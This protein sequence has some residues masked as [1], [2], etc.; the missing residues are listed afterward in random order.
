MTRA[1]GSTGTRR[2]GALAALGLAAVTSLLAPDASGQPSGAGNSP[3]GP[4]AAAANAQQI[5]R[6]RYLAAAGDC[7][8][9]HTL[10]RTAPFSGGRPVE[11]P[12]GVVLSANLTPDPETGI[13]RYDNETFYRALHEGI[14]RNGHHLYPAFP[15]PYY[16]RV[17]REDSDAL[18]AYLRSLPPVIHAIDR[19]QL[20]FPFNFRPMVAVW[21][22]LYLDKH[23]YQQDKAQSAEWNRGAYLVEG[24]GHCQACHTPRNRLGGPEKDEAFRGGRFADWFAPDITPNRRTGIGAWGREAVIEFLRTG[25]NVHS[26]AAGEMAE[27]VS[28]STSRMTDADIGAVATYLASL[29][30]SPPATITKPSS[31]QMAQGEALWRDNCAACHREDAKGV[32]RALPPILASA[33]LQQRDPTT[34]LHYILA[35]AQHRPTDAAPTG[36][37]MPAFG[38]KLDDS[39]IAAV[40]SYAR[41]QWGNQ[42]SPVTADQVAKLR[43]RLAN[44][45]NASTRWPPEVTP[46]HDLAHPGAATWSTAGTDSR[47]NGTPRAGRPAQ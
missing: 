34:V 46:A 47:D 25:R 13:G 43:S 2:L 23:G 5:E 11:T 26:G 10:P 31:G 3:P 35:G 27:V 20:H 8:A 7:V 38:W 41:N 39:E 17:T 4:S 28:F 19:N 42:A 30:P 22:L 36:F 33:N 12:F 44:A 40:A 32:P 15:Y 29:R 1:T 14:D 21:N 6:G 37:A 45:A 9:C 24:L 16:A 18:L